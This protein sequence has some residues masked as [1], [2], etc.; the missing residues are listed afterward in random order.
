M[1]IPFSLPGLKKVTNGELAGP[2]PICGGKDRFRVWPDEKK[3]GGY[4]WLCRGCDKH[5]D[6]IDLY[7]L[8]TGASYPEA[9]KALNVETKMTGQRRKS[10]GVQSVVLQS[11]PNSR[12]NQIEIPNQQWR[13]RAQALLKNC[14]INFDCG[15]DG[16][17]PALE[18]LEAIKFER[19]LQLWAC[20]Q[21][22]I[23]YNKADRY[24][25][26]AQW[27]LE[28]KE[29]KLRIP[30]GIIIATRRRGF[31]IVGL[32]VRRPDIEIKNN[33]G[34]KYWQIAGSARN[35]LFICGHTNKPVF[36]VESALDAVLVWQYGKDKVASVAL[37]GATK[38]MDD[39]TRDFIKRAPIQ[40]IAYDK[41]RAGRGAAKK[42][43]N[44]F[45]SAR[46]IPP[47]G[48]KDIGEMHYN[49]GNGGMRLEEWLPAALKIAGG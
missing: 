7:R 17:E 37:M 40:I 48:G 24:E 13:Q 20:L 25:L 18:V 15:W 35:L 12:L 27:G 28:P 26:R 30:Q 21:C 8:Q 42:L 49:Y 34:P 47:I 1:D 22:G 36:I 19:G 2:C 38:E 46:V 10:S 41:D 11:E 23:G 39:K 5:G 43:Q 14:Q 44:I 4:R 32:T 29:K 33:G 6:G 9:C 31:G 16:D 45:P 3:G